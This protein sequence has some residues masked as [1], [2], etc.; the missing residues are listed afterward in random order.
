M[1]RII[2]IAFVRCIP[3]MSVLGKQYRTKA[4]AVF[5]ALASA[6]PTADGA[7]LINLCAIWIG[8]ER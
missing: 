2:D 3:N 5:E 1:T 8:H 6:T 4:K 7:V